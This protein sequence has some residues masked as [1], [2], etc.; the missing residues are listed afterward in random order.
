MTLT[1]ITSCMNSECTQFNFSQHPSFDIWL[2]ESKLQILHE[3]QF[4]QIGPIR[5]L[6]NTKLCEHFPVPDKHS[7]KYISVKAGKLFSVYAVK[8]HK[9]SRNI[10]PFI[11]NLDTIWWCVV[12]N[13]LLPYWNLKPG[14]SSQ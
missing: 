14:L 7:S 5:K 10:V 8:A 2:Q 13:N 1:I 4:P 9:G 6:Q 12:N 11:L 3:Y